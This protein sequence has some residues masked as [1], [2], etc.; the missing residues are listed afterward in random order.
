MNKK[1][2][3]ESLIELRAEIEKELSANQLGSSVENYEHGINFCNE[4]IASVNDENLTTTPELLLARFSRYAIDSL[5]WTGDIMK[6]FGES[7][8]IIKREYSKK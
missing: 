4:I 7:Q 2:V 6:K 8:E 3:I 1:E 5:P